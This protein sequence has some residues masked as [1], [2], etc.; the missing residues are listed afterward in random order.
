LTPLHNIIRSRGWASSRTA[1]RLVREESFIVR[2]SNEHGLLTGSKSPQED[3]SSNHGLEFSDIPAKAFVVRNR[4]D[5]DG[6][7]SKEVRV[8]GGES[9]AGLGDG[10][11]RLVSEKYRNL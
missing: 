3:F 10:V 8:G 4:R 9:V 1:F 6:D 2:F 11:D 5:G 7:I